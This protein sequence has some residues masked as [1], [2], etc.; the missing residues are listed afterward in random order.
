MCSTII[1]WCSWDGLPEG[2]NCS[3]VWSFW[4]SELCSIDQNSSKR[5]CAGREGSRVILSAL[6]LTLDEYS[7][8][9]VWRV[10]P[11]IRPAVRTTLRKSSVGSWAEPDNYWSAEDGF[12][13]VNV[14]LQVLRYCCVQESEWLH[15]SHSAV[16]DGEWG[17]SRGVST[18]L[19]VL[20]SRLLRL[21]QTASSLTSCL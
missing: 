8:W 4:C 1:V 21:H 9:R 3:C 16:Y 5:E 12:P 11:M 18:V 19:S 14:P 10:V 7:S 6:L 2:R 15:C 17:E 20:S 13:L